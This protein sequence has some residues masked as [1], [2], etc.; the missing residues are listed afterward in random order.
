MTPTNLKPGDILFCSSDRFLGKAIKWATDSEFSHVALYVEVWGVPFVIDAQKDGIQ[1]RMYDQWQNEYGY[2]VRAF[3]APYAIDPKAISLRAATKAGFTAYDFPSL[4]L[5]HPIA[6]LSGKWQERNDSEDMMTCSE[7]VAWV[8]AIQRS[9]RMSPQ[10][11][12]DWVLLNK[13][14]E[15][16]E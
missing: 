16:K 7:F 10:D 12:F 11:L 5:R 14:I 8:Y 9:Y 15:I 3:R 1:F 4:L 13:F 2:K 6:L